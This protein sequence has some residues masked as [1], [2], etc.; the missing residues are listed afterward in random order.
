M[1]G[2]GADE[3]G[4]I[5]PGNLSIYRTSPLFPDAHKERLAFSLLTF[6]DVNFTFYRKPIETNRYRNIFPSQNPTPDLAFGVVASSPAQQSHEL[7]Y[8]Y[9]G[10]TILLRSVPIRADSSSFLAKSEQM[11]S[12]LDLAGTQVFIE[13]NPTDPS[14]SADL[15]PLRKRLKEKVSLSALELDLGYGKTLKV[16]LKDLATIRSDWNDPVFVYKL[17]ERL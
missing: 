4:C 16:P 11:V 8:E 17:P 14:L 5:V 1:G 13:V 15:D 10:S 7:T 9:E 12:V 2:G 3:H 6:A